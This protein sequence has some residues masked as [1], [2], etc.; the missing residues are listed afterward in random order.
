MTRTSIPR[1]AAAWPMS[2]DTKMPLAV[3]ETRTMHRRKRPPF[4]PSIRDAVAVIFRVVGADRGT[5]VRHSEASA[6][7]ALVPAPAL[8]GELWPS[9]ARRLRRTSTRWYG[10]AARPCGS[11]RA[12]RVPG[13]VI[14]PAVRGPPELA[15]IRSHGPAAYQ[16]ACG[17]RYQHMASLSGITLIMPASG[18]LAR[19]AREG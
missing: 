1:R 19:T 3:P 17:D 4:A 5:T 8:A 15:A 13:L 10:A 6:P 16:R 14:A 12:S 18:M 11:R 9:S 2:S 7:D